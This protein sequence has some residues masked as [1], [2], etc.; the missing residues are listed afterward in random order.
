MTIYDKMCEEDVKTLAEYMC[1]PSGGGGGDII[2]IDSE[3]RLISKQEDVGIV[4]RDDIIRIKKKE[5]L[6]VSETSDTIGIKII[7]D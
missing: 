7:E 4:Q 6:L 2:V 5:P 1:L 3:L